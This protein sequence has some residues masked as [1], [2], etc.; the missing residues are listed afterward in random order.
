MNMADPNYPQNYPPQGYQQQ[1]PGYQQPPGYYQQPGY[2]PPPYW[3][4]PQGYAPPNFT[5][6]HKLPGTAVAAS[7]M[8]IIYGSLGLLGNLIALG[9][10][11]GKAGGGI[12][13]IGIAVG[14]LV[15]GITTLTGKAKGM[16][17]NG[18]ASIVLGA[19]VS[20]AILLLGALIR[21]FHPPAVLIL[22]GLLFGLMLI[23]AGIFALVGN[24]AYK[25]YRYTRGFH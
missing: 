2:A 19:L 8:W 22:V 21:G 15:A 20:I 12:V 10:S 9:A 24:K 7:I 11:G 23:G 17:A 13:G 6:R 25:E 4:Q 18:I 14:F 5:P 1:Q 3:Q 16:M